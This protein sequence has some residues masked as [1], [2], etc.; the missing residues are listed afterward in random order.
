MSRLFRKYEK[1]GRVTI[2]Y[3]T[4]IYYGTL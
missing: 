4:T 3:E 2:E 1:A